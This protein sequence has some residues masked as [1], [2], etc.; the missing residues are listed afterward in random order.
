MKR[1]RSHV[2][3]DESRIALHTLLPSNWVKSEFR[4]DYGLDMQITI[5]KGE[6]VSNNVFS[7][8]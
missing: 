3:E 2:L 6:E 8:V 5:V 1:P 7:V 4:E